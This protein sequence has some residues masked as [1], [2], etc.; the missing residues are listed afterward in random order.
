M[1]SII[2]IFSI[3]LFV[4]VIH[5]SCSSDWL[6]RN[7]SDVL[8]DEQVFSDKAS[9]ISLLANFYDRLPANYLPNAF[10][11]M[12]D[13]DE[14]MWSGNNTGADRMRN[15]YIIYPINAWQGWYYQMVYE[16]NLSIEKIDSS[17]LSETDKRIFKAEFRF[18]RAQ[19]YF[20]MVK[21]MGGVP[22]ITQTYTYLPGVTDISSLQ[23]PRAT[24]ENIYLFVASEIDN[25]KTDLAVNNSSQTRA[26]QY[27][28]LA[29]KSRAM[30][31]AASIA[32]YG[33]GGP[34]AK[35][36]TL[37]LKGN[38]AGIPYEK[39]NYFYEESL[40]ASVE[41][42]NG[43]VYKLMMNDK[44]SDNFYK[45]ICNKTGNSEVIF[46]KDYSADKPHGFTWRNIPYSYRESASEGS[47]LSPS[48]NLVEMYDNIDGT[49]SGNLGDLLINNVT[50]TNLHFYNSLEEIF[51]NKD[52]RLKATILV[53]GGSF[54]SKKVQL[55]AG[56]L[57]YNATTGKYSK[58]TST[59]LGDMDANG[60]PVLGLDGPSNFPYI[61]NTGFYLHK[62]VDETSGS[63]ID[64]QSGKMW[65]VWY[66]MGEIYLN[67][68]E[69]SF[70]LYGATGIGAVT[71]NSSEFYI[72]KIR[73][74]AGFSTS[75]L[76]GATGQTLTIDKIRKERACELAFEDHRLWDQKRWRTAHII[77]NGTPNN[78]SK[79]ST[80]WI[81]G[82]F[83]YLVVGGPNNGKYVL[84]RIT[85]QKF[86]QPRNFQL[87]NYYSEIAQDWIDRN[88]K[89]ARNPLH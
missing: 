3:I 2:N 87:N 19:I 1:K 74:R 78:A 53:P 5:S 33:Y 11:G 49:S 57:I 31:Y 51:A 67:A 77:W 45:A 36:P 10:E 15:G 39:A 16:L 61:S 12:A 73:E 65:W 58:K 8:T 81:H 40:K 71:P 69:A 35:T 25:I 88:P 24:E 27:T 72:N 47:N 79:T 66:R 28:A 48:L 59:K 34:N 84:E 76:F 44:S 55:I 42:I 46:A 50:G 37:V 52:V 26:N 75:G 43:N 64:A 4:L 41:I 23:F 85:P 86:V 14:A 60:L 68:A 56:Q 29:L 30:L 80:Q 62:Y 83:P 21:R 63:A 22:L 70:E 18:L 38:E 13:L 6:D 20:E 9:V 89:L 54:R 82:L 17:P 7:P 32:K